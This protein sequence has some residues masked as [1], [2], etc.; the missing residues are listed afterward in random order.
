MSAIGGIF[1]RDG[2]PCD[3]ASL[4]A[5]AARLRHRAPDG[6]ATWSDGP[7]GLSHG[8]LITTP[9][10]PMKRSRSPTRPRESRSHSTAGSTT[11]P[12]CCG[13]LDSTA[14]TTPRSATRRWCCG[15]IARWASDCVERLL[16]DFAFAIWDGPR[17]SLLCARDHLGLR[18]F[19]Y[20]VMPD[21]V[22]WASEAGALARFDGTL[23]AV[24][25]G[26]V[27]EH[28]SGIITSTSDTVFR[29]IFRL[30][31]AHLLTADAGGIRVRRYWSPDLRAE[32]RYDDPDE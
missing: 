21:R 16:G 28:L 32:I 2:R 12:S 30:P 25:E 5:L 18:P 26:M 31:A 23:P 6:T 8:R 13:R 27:A 7:A 29:D 10:R 9:N 22:A 4:A 14:S 15:C 20:R 3:P 1:H 17:A 19:C 24:N 11:G